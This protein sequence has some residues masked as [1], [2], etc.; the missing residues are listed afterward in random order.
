MCV[1]YEVQSL[2][3]NVIKERKDLCGYSFLRLIVFQFVRVFLE[4]SQWW[5]RTKFSCAY[6][7]ADNN[8]KKYFLW[9]FSF[10]LTFS[11]VIVRILEI[12]RKFHWLGMS[13][14]VSVGGLWTIDVETESFSPTILIYYYF[15]LGNSNCY[16]FVHA[17]HKTFMYSLSI[18]TT[19]NI[20]SLLSPEPEVIVTFKECNQRITRSSIAKK[21]TRERTHNQSS[22]TQGTKKWS[23]KFCACQAHTANTHTHIRNNNEAK[24]I[25]RGMPSIY[26]VIIVIFFSFSFIHSIFF[27]FFCKLAIKV[28]NLINHVTKQREFCYT[29]TYNT[30][31]N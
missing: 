21:E 12:Y 25:T 20:T 11:M 17:A 6:T 19:H 29:C 3:I 7:F 23:V 15:Y 22:M 26:A 13:W 27:P 18:I 28:S 8:K 4:T 10:L 31:K 30:Y 9:L 1:C 5:L 14:K 2:I 16:K 24:F